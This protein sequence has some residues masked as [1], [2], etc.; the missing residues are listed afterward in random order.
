MIKEL[1]VS[2]KDNIESKS[3]NPFFGTFILIWIFKNWNLFYSLFN[4]NPK[5]TLEQKRNFII[6]HFKENPLLETILWSILKAIIVLVISYLLINLS[7]LIV[8]FFEKK[9]TPLMYKWT[10]KNSV[11]LKSVYDTSEEN[12]ILLEKK[13]EDERT[14]KLRLQED[15][16]KLE[17]RLAEFVLKHQ[18]TYDNNLEIPKTQEPDSAIIPSSNDRTLLIFN[19][20]KRDGRLN[21]FEEF[22]E[23]I[24]NGITIKKENPLVR[25]FRTLGLIA[26]SSSY[27]SDYSYYKLT[28]DGKKLHETLLFDKLK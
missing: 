13:V 22:A 27:S 10:D 25:E 26:Q 2:F 12:R 20:F 9:I 7:R 23:N 15:Y 19:K 16:E 3:T 4:F 14:A 5:T 18:E 6:Q 21:E 28:E 8:N 24:L 17:K 1:L 11:V